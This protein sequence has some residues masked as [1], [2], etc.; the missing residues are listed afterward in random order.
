MIDLSRNEFT[1]HIPPEL[2]ENLKSMK[3]IQVD[4]SSPKYMGGYYYQDSV[5]VTM[6][7]S[8]FK[9][10]RIL[11]SFTVI[12]F[13]SNH[14][15]GSIPNELGELNSLIVL[16]FS[17][18]SLAGNI[19]PSL[20]KL[21]ALESVGAITETN[22]FTNGLVPLTGSS[23][24]SISGTFWSGSAW[25]AWSAAS[26]SETSSVHAEPT[27]SESLDLSSNKLQGRIPVQLTDLT[28]LG[29]LNLSNNNLEGHI[30]LANHF[31]TFSNDSFNGNSGLCGFPLS[32]KCG[33]DQELESPPSIVADESE[34]SIW[35][36]AAMGY[37]SGLVLGLSMGYIVF[38]TGRPRWLVKMIKR[39]PQMRRR[40]RRNG[41]RKN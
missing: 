5:I 28:F 11:T 22:R 29:A 4:K 26:S 40:I 23:S 31:D 36:I 16:N 7:G 41:R 15:K 38:T 35:K 39:N 33:N 24:I 10:E 2:F 37:G 19:P 20:G 18:N 34:T 3:D 12:D 8:D 32:K 21:A 25:S 6:K 9:F 1:G 13:S 27:S 17:H 14:F 30:P